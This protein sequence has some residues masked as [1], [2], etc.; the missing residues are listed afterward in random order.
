M[1]AVYAVYQTQTISQRASSSCQRRR[2]CASASRSKN[3]S[4]TT[5]LRDARFQGVTAYCASSSID[6]RLLSRPDLV[7]LRG[8]LE[9]A[10]FLGLTLALLALFEP[11]TVAVHFQDVNV[12][13]QPV[14]QRAGQPL[15]PEHA[16]PLVEW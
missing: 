16:G 3:A 12:M 9:P 4:L 8:R 7:P 1:K 15:G 2:E 11:V 14:E 13:G 10:G 5:E 6:K